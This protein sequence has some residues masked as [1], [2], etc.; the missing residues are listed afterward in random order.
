[1]ELQSASEDKSDCRERQSALD[2]IDKKH[3]A[4]L[5]KSRIF[6]ND[7]LSGRSLM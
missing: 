3:L 4:S 7:S 2:E 1:M 6:D 5:G